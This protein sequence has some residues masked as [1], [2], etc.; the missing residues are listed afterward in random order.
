MRTRTLTIFVCSTLVGCSTEDNISIPWPDTDAKIYL[1][2]ETWVWTNS[3]EADR[4]L[5][6]L[7]ST[8]LE[9]RTYRPVCYGDSRW[10]LRCVCRGAH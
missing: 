9:R 5:C 6:V 4:Y 8:G 3:W 2:P 7:S 10:A 1:G